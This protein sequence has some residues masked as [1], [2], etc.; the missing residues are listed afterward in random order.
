MISLTCSAL[1]RTVF[2]KGGACGALSHTHAN[3]ISAIADI[4][5]GYERPAP[6]RLVL[7][8]F[9][10]YGYELKVVPIGVHGAENSLH[11]TGVFS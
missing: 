7:M 8:C 2:L 11:S 5:K 3:V 4:S 1:R 6:L 9:C 10:T